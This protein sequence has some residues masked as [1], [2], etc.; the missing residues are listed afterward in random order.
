M[1]SP[2]CLVELLE[3]EVL[4]RKPYLNMAMPFT[5]P[6]IYVL[7]VPQRKYIVTLLVVTLS[8][9]RGGTE[10]RT[11]EQKARCWCLTCIEGDFNAQ[12]LV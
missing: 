1:Q 10:N 8:E 4:K 9:K 7:G 5:Q 12:V 3:V 6:H 11:N 2:V